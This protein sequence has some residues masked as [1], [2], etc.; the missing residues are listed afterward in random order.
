MCWY[1]SYFIS[2]VR[3]PVTPRASHH[4]ALPWVAVFLI[5]VSSSSSRPLVTTHP[6][7]KE[8]SRLRWRGVGVMFIRPSSS[9]ALFHH[10]SDT[11]QFSSNFLVFGKKI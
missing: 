4:L 7:Q 11:S 8:R 9:C 6:F 5:L 10:Y 2:T 3:G 1:T